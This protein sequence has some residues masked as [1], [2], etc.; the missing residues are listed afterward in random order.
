MCFDVARSFIECGFRRSFLKVTEAKLIYFKPVE[1]NMN[2][3]HVCSSQ[4][5]DIKKT[6]KWIA[7][8]ELAIGNLDVTQAASGIFI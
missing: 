5:S 6:I 4:C 3:I 1:T 2:V 8:I 7:R